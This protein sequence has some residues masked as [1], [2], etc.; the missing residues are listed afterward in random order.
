MKN[1]V[2]NIICLLGAMVIVLL[3]ITD[4]IMTIYYYDGRITGFPLSTIVFSVIL[5]YLG[6]AL[7]L[8]E[9]YLIVKRFFLK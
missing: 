9:V 2:W 6:I 8:L 1:K 4:I 5:A 3:L 7:L